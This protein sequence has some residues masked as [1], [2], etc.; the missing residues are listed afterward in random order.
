M[1]IRT[2]LSSILQLALATLSLFDLLN[3]CFSSLFHTHTDN[4]PSPKALGHLPGS[5]IKCEVKYN[6]APHRILSFPLP[7]SF[8][9][10]NAEAPGSGGEPQAEGAFPQMFILEILP[11]SRGPDINELLCTCHLALTMISVLLI[12][13]NKIYIFNNIY[14]F[15]EVFSDKSQLSLHFTLN[16][17]SLNV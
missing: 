7:S 16:Y 2:C 17:F 15:S 9:H 4:L 5:E 14:I 1:S 8:L 13:F 12:L 10:K 6:S 11:K 3:L